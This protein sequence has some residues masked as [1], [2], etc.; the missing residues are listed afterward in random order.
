M[1][2]KQNALEAKIAKIEDDL[3]KQTSF[4]KRL[5]NVEAKVTS[6][7]ERSNQVLKPSQPIAPTKN[8]VAN[9]AATFK[10]INQLSIP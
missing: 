2:D 9:P 10:N 4:V 8:A 1:Q 6:G 7:T 5:E 3:R